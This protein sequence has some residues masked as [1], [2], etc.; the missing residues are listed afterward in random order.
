MKINK[1]LM[2]KLNKDDYLL[3]SLQK[4]VEK[5]NISCGLIQGIGAVQN[6]N[7]GYYNQ[8]SFKYQEISFNQPL[9]VT[10][11]SGNI[12]I[13][14]GKPFI[15]CHITCADERGKVFGGHLGEKTKVFAFEYIIFSFEGGNFVRKFDSNTGLYLWEK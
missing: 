10:N 12:S 11:L 15:H 1:I 13:R 2:G 5:N 8:E 14:D 7:C 6:L 4:I 9:E 3:E